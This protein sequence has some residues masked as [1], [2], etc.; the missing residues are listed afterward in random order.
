MFKEGQKVQH[1]TSKMNCSFNNIPAQ[2]TNFA[3][4][5]VCV[6]PINSEK[7]P[8]LLFVTETLKHN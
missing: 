5:H 3:Y 1:L 4:Q 7:I 8:T 6:N 2:G